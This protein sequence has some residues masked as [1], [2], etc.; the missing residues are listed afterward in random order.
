M[1]KFQE[2]LE[3]VKERFKYSTFTTLEEAK[4]EAELQFAIDTL[5]E[6]IDKYT[7]FNEDESCTYMC[8]VKGMLEEELSIVKDNLSITEKALDKACEDFARS[9]IEKVDNGEVNYTQLQ[10]LKEKYKKGYLLKES[11]K[12]E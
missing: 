1:N 10:I 9:V 4:Y 3:K 6:L 2:A 5:Q 7:K 12:D 8:D 11:D